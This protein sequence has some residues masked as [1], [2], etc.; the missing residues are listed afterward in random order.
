MIEE[1]AS[2]ASKSK[3]K[4]NSA[5]ILVKVLGGISLGDVSI[6]RDFPVTVKT[7]FPFLSKLT[8]N[9]TILW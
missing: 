9:K 3:S 5:T 7:A 1:T 2:S 4:V 6:C 8:F